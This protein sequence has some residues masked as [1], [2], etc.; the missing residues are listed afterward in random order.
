M[1]NNSMPLHLKR[2]IFLCLLLSLFLSGCSSVSH[3]SNP[4][5]QSAQQ[6]QH[7]QIKGKLA[8]AT[9]NDNATGYLT[10]KQ[11]QQHFD[12]F[13]SGPF[14]AKASRLSGD[15]QSASLLLAGWEQ[16]RLAFSA[17][18]L[19]QEYLG[20]AIPLKAL[21]FWVKGLPADNAIQA[22]TVNDQHQLTYLKQYDWDIR[23]SRYQ[24]VDGYWLP[25]LIKISGQDYRFTLAIQEWI[26]HD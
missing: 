1:Q 15:E 9:P 12:L 17:E 6:L 19:M 14:G 10:W 24:Q 13:I 4:E 26:T 20:W 7:W 3:K 23:Y 18:A 11:E 25:H 21:T 2:S 8:V 16:P 5:P 22:Q